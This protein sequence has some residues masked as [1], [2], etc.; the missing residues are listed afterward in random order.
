MPIGA[1]E[2]GAG[3]F[4]AAGEFIEVSVSPPVFRPSTLKN[5][6]IFKKP[7]KLLQRSLPNL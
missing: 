5:L 1:L 6:K 4:E 2:V 3:V 7:E